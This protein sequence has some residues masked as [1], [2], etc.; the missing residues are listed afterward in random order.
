[1]KWVPAILTVFACSSLAAQPVK[2]AIQKGNTYYQQQQYDKA[3]TQYQKA[4]DAAPND[5][6][7]T[8]NLGNSLLKQNKPEEAAKVYNDLAN[9]TTDQHMKAQASYNK[10]V[11]LSQQK[12]LEESIEAYKEALRNDPNDKD[13]R[14]NLQKALLELKKKNNPKKD[15]DQQKKKKEQEQQQKKQ[16]QPKIS[17]QE[18]E[19]RL[20]LLEQKEKQV[21]QRLQKDKNKGGGSQ[22]KDW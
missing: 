2:E 3:A 5:Q 13:A 10:G 18:A 6:T 11:V 9:T 17:K 19:Q 16:S 12:K 22:T 15:N 4:L 8:F 1:M 20:K 7:A 21:Q 14:E